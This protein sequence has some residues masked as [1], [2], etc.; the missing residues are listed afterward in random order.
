MKLGN[1]GKKCS[2]FKKF[3]VTQWK[4]ESKTIQWKKSRNCDVTEDKKVLPV[5]GLCISLNFRYSSKFRRNLQSPVWKRHV[6]AYLWCTD[7]AAKKYYYTLNSL[8]LFWLAESVLWTFEISARDV[9]T[10]DYTIIMSVKDTQG[11]GL[12][13]HA[14]PQCM[15]AKGN[16]VKFARFVLL[17]VSEEAKT[18][19]PFFSFNV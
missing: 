5:F 13:C 12:S 6:G 15:I 3:A 16:N 14:W 18:W 1:S 4:I 2:N 7:M 10:A 8:S 11:H 17:P 9:I 19:L